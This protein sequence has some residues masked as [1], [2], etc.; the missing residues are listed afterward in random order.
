MGRLKKNPAD[1]V[2]HIQYTTMNKALS[3]DQV[4]FIHEHC[5]HIA[6]FFDL[7]W[8]QLSSTKQED[9]SGYHTMDTMIKVIDLCRLAQ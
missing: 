8:D 5:G 1:K 9:L 6:E 4:K 2:F 3:S 7:M